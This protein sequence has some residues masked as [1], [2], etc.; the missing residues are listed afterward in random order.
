MKPARSPVRRKK[1]WIRILR[2]TA[3]LAYGILIATS[4]LGRNFIVTAVLLAGSLLFGAWFCGWLCPFGAVQEW[5]SRLGRRILGRQYRVPR[6]LDRYL[7]YLRYLLLAAGL[8]GL[9]F[10]AF[11]S[12]PY[13]T[14]L[15]ALTLNTAYITLPA[16]GLLALFLAASFFLERP[17]CRYFCTE[18]AGYG[19]LSLCRVFSIRRHTSS[20]LACGAC[21]RVCPAG[22]RISKKKYIRDHHCINCLECLAACPVQG[23]LTYSFII[24][25]PLKE[26]TC[27]T[28]T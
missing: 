8:A 21:D 13:Q 5:I 7:K 24:K 4:L 12:R 6:V 15:G 26:K 3:Q 20:C 16:W 23:A 11:A 2:I 27:E 9:G 18:G 19:A 17:F 25:K 1:L 22:I 10:L 28:V 14:F